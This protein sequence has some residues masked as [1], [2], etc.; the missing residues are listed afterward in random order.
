MTGTQGFTL[1]EVLVALAIFMMSIY[2]VGAITDTMRLNSSNMS[3]L[4]ASQAIQDVFERTARKFQAPVGYGKLTSVDMP[5]TVNGYN[6]S[7]KIC[8]ASTTSDACINQVVLDS[9]TSSYTANS[10]VNLLRMT[11]AYTPSMARRGSSVVTA[12]EFAKP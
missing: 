1:I 11:V 3:T 5:K 12:L 4:E 7:I 9:S 6:W 8:E 10:S 2:F